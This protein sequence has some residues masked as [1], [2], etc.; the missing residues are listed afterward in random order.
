MK[1]QQDIDF[2]GLGWIKGE[3]DATLKQAQEALE[4]FV[5]DTA[6]TGLMR[7]CSAYL[8]QVQGALRV[9]ELYGAAMVADEM[10]LLAKA[11]VDGRILTPDD[12]Y[13]VLLRGIVQLPNYLERVQEGH[14]DV[15]V[16]LLPL[17]NDLRA[18]R[19]EKLLTES[20]LFSTGKL[21]GR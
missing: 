21:D 14:K 10:E 4:S 17:L 13:A 20:V 15:P 2:N 3:I 19:G 11:I 1:L 9:V 18:C 12:A 7:L 6:D 8:H 5:E 16:V